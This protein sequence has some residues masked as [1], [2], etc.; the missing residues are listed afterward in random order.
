[1]KL[2]GSDI[3]SHAFS[4][5]MRGYD[6]LEVDAFLFA[7]A[8]QVDRLVRENEQLGLQCADLFEEYN[9]LKKEHAEARKTLASLPA[10]RDEASAW[11]G[12]LV[13]KAEADADRIL[14]EAESR[15]ARLRA[16]AEREA[17]RLRGEASALRE[18]RDNLFADFCATLRSQTRTLEEESRRAGVDLERLMG[19]R[20]GTVINLSQKA[21]GDAS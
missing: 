4:R 11:A 15:A 13:R 6:R 9:R 2:T 10:L 3:R 8:E 21:E 12:E 20:S 19:E 14:D 1:M 17:A 7:A 5:R 18:A 16:D